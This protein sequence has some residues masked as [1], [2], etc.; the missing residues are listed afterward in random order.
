MTKAEELLLRCA[1]RWKQIRHAYLHVGTIDKPTAHVPP[2]RSTMLDAEHAL[3]SA[4]EAVERERMA[5]QN[6]GR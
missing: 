5:R 4:V 2:P 6:G 1:L 3:V